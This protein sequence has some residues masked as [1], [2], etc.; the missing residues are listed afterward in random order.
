[1][2]LFLVLYFTFKY[3]KLI[4]SGFFACELKNIFLSSSTL[5]KGATVSSF[6]NGSIKQWLFQNTAF[7]TAICLVVTIYSCFI[8]TFVCH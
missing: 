3:A 5:E 2:A 1:M 6:Q 8:L 7:V 4:S